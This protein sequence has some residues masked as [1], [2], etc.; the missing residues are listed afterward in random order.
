MEIVKS[1]GYVAPSP[2]DAATAMR[3]MNLGHS[4]GDGDYFFSRGG[5]GKYSTFT[6]TDTEY[7]GRS[8]VVGALPGLRVNT[9]INNDIACVG[10]LGFA[11]VLKG[12]R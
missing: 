6:V 4:L 2:C 3:I 1:K 9:I 10:I 5:G 12:I 11:E 8:L 7:Q